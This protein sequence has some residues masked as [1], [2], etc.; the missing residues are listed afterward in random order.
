MYNKSPLLEQHEKVTL[1]LI[2]IVVGFFILLYFIRNQSPKIINFPSERTVVIAF[3]DSLIEGVGGTDN[4]FINHL[5]NLVNYDIENMGVSGETTRDALAR[6]KKVIDKS[7]RIVLISL[8]GNDF[9][10]RRPAAEVKQDLNKIVSQIQDSGSMVVILGVPGYR[11]LHRDV[12]EA[13]RS[14]YVSNILSGLITNPQYMSDAVHPNDE[15]Y[16]KIAKKIQP[17]LEKLLP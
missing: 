11:N 16:K 4:G 13:Q 10:Q 5:E 15:G 8:G 14:A 7:P 6:V 1:I 2:L 12:A 9:L 17:V 3:G